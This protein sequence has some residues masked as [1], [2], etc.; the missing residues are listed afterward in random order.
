MAVGDGGG[1]VGHGNAGSRWDVNFNSRGW[2]H[3]DRANIR[4]VRRNRQPT[5]NGI[6]PTYLLIEDFYVLNLAFGVGEE[7]I[8]ISMLICTLRAN[9]IEIVRGNTVILAC[10]QKI[11][12]N[13]A[14][15]DL[16]IC[17]GSPPRLA[18]CRAARRH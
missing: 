17:G 2:P 1:E 8:V 16:C 9:V 4:E 3:L 10:I 12:P 15:A 18:H 6:W 5:G 7:T 14:I 11:C 13:S